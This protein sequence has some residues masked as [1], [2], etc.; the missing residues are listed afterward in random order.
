M[1]QQGKLM[2]TLKVIAITLLVV[3]ASI[4]LMSAVLS[5]YFEPFTLS[6]SSSASAST[7][8][9]DPSQN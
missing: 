7:S 1:S 8:V 4:V 9:Y 6:Q 3:S 2:L 5:N